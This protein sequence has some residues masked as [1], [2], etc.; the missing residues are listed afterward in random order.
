MR[1]LLDTHAL[2][3]WIS[4]NDSLSAAAKAAI[5]D[6]SNTNYVSAASTWE[7][8]TKYRI[9]KLPSAA[10]IGGNIDLFIEDRGFVGLPVSPRH[11][12]VSGGLPGLH[13]DPFDRILIAQAIVE[14]MLL[15]S[16][17]VL[18]DGYGVERFW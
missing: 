4:G 15:V 8:A 11:G 12:W 17:E 13:R 3:W 5:G 2:L 18:F 14:G 16:N 6:D 1:L 10:A 9:G 7:I